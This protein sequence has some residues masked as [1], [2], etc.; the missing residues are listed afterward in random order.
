MTEDEFVWEHFKLNAEQRMQGFNFYIA[1]SIFSMGGVYA[2]FE[3]NINSNLIGLLG[4]FVSL[5]SFVFFLVDTRSKR[6]LEITIPAMKEL[7]SK[8]PETY[9]L[10]KNDS[11]R[12]GYFLDT[13]LPYVPYFSHNLHLA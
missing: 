5:L 12:R 1:F 4:L 11:K 13:P 10:F 9:Q 6:L 3:K 2:A 8:F 7:E